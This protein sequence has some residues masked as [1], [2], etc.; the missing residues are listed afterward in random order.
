MS[1]TFSSCSRE[2]SWKGSVAVTSRSTSSTSHSSRA[3]IETRCW[4]STSSG[5]CGITVSSIAPS[6]IRRATTAHSSRSARNLGKMR[7]RE[8]SPS[9]WPARPTRCR[10]RLTDFGD[11]TWIT[12]STAPMSIPSSRDDV[13]TR[14]GSCPDL[15]I[16]STTSPLLVG[17][18][19]VVGSG[20]FRQGTIALAAGPV[21]GEGTHRP[22]AVLELPRGGPPS[23]APPAEERL[24][25]RSVARQ[26]VAGSSSQRQLVEALGDALGGS[27]VVDEDDRRG[28]FLDELQELGVDRGPDRADVGVG[29]AL[30]GV[31]VGVGKVR[32]PRFAHVLNRHDD[33]QIQ[34][35][36]HPS[37]HNLALP[38][39]SNQELRNP[40][41]R[42]LR[43]RE[44]YPLDQL[45]PFRGWRGG[46]GASRTGRG[47]PAVPPSPATG[48]AAGDV[49]IRGR[50]AWSLTR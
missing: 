20:D 5:F 33:L 29:L 18:G 13:A 2:S 10:P 47:P 49:G 44:P 28:V 3:A 12:R 36:G 11:S 4:A 41:Q 7:P 42:P 8:T 24:S 15:S 46:R 9:E 22:L 14:Q 50:D 30:G 21:V 45:R 48:P 19:A 27:A 35:L 32:S 6:R 26:L 40:L 1:S 34:L 16:S 17:E 39:R 25:R 43:R 37:I 23:P 31:A 38:L